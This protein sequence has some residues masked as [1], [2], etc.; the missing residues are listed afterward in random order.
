[1]KRHV[2][3]LPLVTLLAGGS[4]LYL[5]GYSEPPV[6]PDWQLASIASDPPPGAVTVRFSGTSTLLFSDGA[7]AWMIDGWFT[8][9][10]IV[11]TLFGE[12]APDLAAI[13]Y[14]LE[15]NEVSELAT[16]IPVH[17]KADAD[18]PATRLLGI[19]EGLEA[20]GA[21]RVRLLT[22]AAPAGG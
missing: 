12:I 20:A 16:V 13:E 21:R 7:T 18:L 19:L 14:G 17:V 9:P 11:Q 10:G 15:A 4:W 2:W 22:V 1:M 6:D 3:F 8:R 5:F